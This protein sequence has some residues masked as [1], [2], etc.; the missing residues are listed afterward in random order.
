MKR[1]NLFGG[2]SLVA[3]GGA[4]GGGAMVSANAMGSTAGGAPPNVLTMIS[5]AATTARPCSARSRAPISRGFCSGRLQR[6][7][8]GATSGGI[9]ISSQAVP[10][11]KAGG[12][13]AFAPPAVGH[14]VI[15]SATGD[16][17]ALS[18]D[19]LPESAKTAGAT[20]T[21][22]GATIAG[23]PADGQKVTGGVPTGAL[24]VLTSA[25]EA[26]DGTAEEC[27]AMHDEAVK[28][29]S[30]MPANGAVIESGAATKP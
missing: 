12:Q 22:N 3:A 14:G 25:D 18:V 6:M 2:V 29:A 11:D 21:V 27:A 1:N 8:E 19:G 17:P 23:L 4:V 9:V 26:H 16:L 10:V 30:T 7:P 13:P 15:I 5:I 28:M 24:P 20:V